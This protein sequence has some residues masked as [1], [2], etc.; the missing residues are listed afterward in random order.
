MKRVYLLS[1]F[2]LFCLQP[3]AAQTQAATPSQPSEKYLKA[4]RKFLEKKV[5]LAP[6][7][8]HYLQG[9]VPAMVGAGVLPSEIK[10]LLDDYS[11]SAHLSTHLTD[12]YTDDYSVSGHLTPDYIRYMLVINTIATALIVKGLTKISSLRNQ[13]KEALKALAILKKYYQKQPI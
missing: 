3:L 9:I 8:Y 13:K 11:T 4:S 7:S 6:R 2:S 5:N 10:S 12:D 1:L